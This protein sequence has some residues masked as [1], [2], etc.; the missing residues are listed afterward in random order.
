VR[1]GPASIHSGSE[2]G[3]PHWAQGFLRG[4]SPNSARAKLAEAKLAAM[5]H[6]PFFNFIL[7]QTGQAC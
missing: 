6:L 7:K 1:R 5:A 3:L 2:I 4:K